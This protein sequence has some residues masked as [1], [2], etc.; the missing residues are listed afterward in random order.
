[1]LLLLKFLFFFLHRKKRSV[2]IINVFSK[3]LI[4][5]HYHLQSIIWMCLC[6]YVWIPWRI[7]FRKT[8][9]LKFVFVSGENILLFVIRF[10]YNNNNSFSQMANDLFFLAKFHYIKQHKSQM[11][12]QLGWLNLI[13]FFIHSFIQAVI[14]QKD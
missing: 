10:F 14:G 5:L 3:C 1:M 9:T 2:G 8:H 12:N 7:F 6:V 13:F 11:F 4:Q